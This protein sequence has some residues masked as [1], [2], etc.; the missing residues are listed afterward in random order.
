MC[1]SNSKGQKHKASLLHLT[2][3]RT[4][5]RK[6]SCMNKNTVPFLWNTSANIKGITGGGKE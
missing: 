5:N 3:L 4:D 2:I 6:K 1:N